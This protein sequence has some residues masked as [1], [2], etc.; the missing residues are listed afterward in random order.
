MIDILL[1]KLQSYHVF[2]LLPLL[3]FEPAFS[4][5]EIGSFSRLSGFV[6]AA[7]WLRSVS[8]SRS[9]THPSGAF[10]WH[11]KR[12]FASTLLDLGT[13]QHPP[14]LNHRVL[15]GV[16]QFLPSIESF[17]KRHQVLN[18]ISLRPFSKL[19]SAAYS[20]TERFVRYL[21]RLLKYLRRSSLFMWLSSDMPPILLKIGCCA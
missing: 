9:T 1:S 5:W 2:C 6:K 16:A 20:M 18:G 3:L 4:T 11:Q 7:S 8:C 21:L 15:G 10:V 12:L 17:G 14:L 19:S 13:I